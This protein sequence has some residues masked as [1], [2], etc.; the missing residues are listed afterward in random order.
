MTFCLNLPYHLQYQLENIY[1]TR[2]TPPPYEP[3]I[4]TITALLDLIVK[5]LQ[6]FYHRQ[7]IHTYRHQAGITKKVVLLLAIGNLPAIHKVL[8]FARVISHYFCSFCTLHKS[9]IENL[10][11]GAWKLQKETEVIIAVE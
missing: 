6:H 8:G 9:N 11:S 1:F 2:I 3:S 7:V 4:T 5:Q 10:N